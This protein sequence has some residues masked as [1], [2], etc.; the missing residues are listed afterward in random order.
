MV[1]RAAVLVVL[2]ACSYTPPG[3]NTEVTPDGL[4][5]PDAPPIDMMPMPMPGDVDGDGIDDS[6]DSCPDDFDPNERDHDGDGIGDPCD[7]CPV[8]LD[9]ADPDQDGDGV[10]D[11]CD[12]GPSTPGHSRV[13][14][15]GFFP[16]DNTLVS[17]WST[18]GAW[19]LL[20]GQLTHTPSANVDSIVTSFEAERAFVMIRMRIDDFSSSAAAAGYVL[21]LQGT[22]LA[23]TAFHQCAISTQSGGIVNAKRTGDPS[24]DTLSW[25]GSLAT[26][27]SVEMEGD[28]RGLFSCK[29]T[30]SI[31]TR[32]VD[33][34]L[35]AQVSGSV[36]LIAQSAGVSYDYLLVVTGP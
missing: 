17:T 6:E 21:G 26:T 9:A 29:F 2:G 12:P 7:K 22:V 13:G 1:R 31:A 35:G 27:T 10:G 14:F 4:V 33:T 20:A 16:E 25:T 5:D 15:V 30:D 8:I 23:P 28:L 11:K 18:T 34:T 19:Q 3:S 32:T 24:G 36:A